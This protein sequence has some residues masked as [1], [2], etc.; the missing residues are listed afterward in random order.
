MLFG[1]PVEPE[2][3]AVPEGPFAAALAVNEA[4]RKAE[5]LLQPGAKLFRE[6]VPSPAQASASSP[7]P[8]PPSN[9]A[10]SLSGG[11]EHLGNDL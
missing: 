1:L 7:A 10:S 8:C 5:T 4:L 9:C 6:G 2:G 3:R 11:P